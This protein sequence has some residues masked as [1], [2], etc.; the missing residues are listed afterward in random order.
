MSFKNSI[1]LIYFNHPHLVYLKDFYNKLYGSYFKK[2]IYFSNCN[3][4]N[5]QTIN[6]SD[7]VNYI[8]TYGGNNTHII[9]IFF[10]RN[11]KNY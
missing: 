1:F 8:Y 2:I 3:D 10:I 7:D 9:L 6:N 5:E 11:I 4:F